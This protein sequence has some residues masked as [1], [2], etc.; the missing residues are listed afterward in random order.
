MQAEEDRKMTTEELVAV[1]AGRGPLDTTDGSV[2]AAIANAMVGLFKSQYE[3][4]VL[5]PASSRG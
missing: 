5:E 4:F 3:T 1:G 2:R